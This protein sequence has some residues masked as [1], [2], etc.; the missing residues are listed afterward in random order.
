MEIPNRTDAE[1]QFARR[2]ARLTERQRKRLVDLLGSSPDPASVPESFWQEVANETEH[3]TLAILYLLFLASSYYHAGGDVAGAGIEST[4]KA[5]IDQ[6]AIIYSRDAASRLAQSYTET[7]RERFDALTRELRGMPPE[8]VTV[9]VVAE[10]SVKV[11]GPARAASVAVTETTAAQSAGG[12]AGTRLV[13]GLS[14][15]DKWIT[16]KDSKVCPVCRPLHRTKRDVW[17]LRFVDG[18]PAHPS[19]RCVIEY[20]KER[21]NRA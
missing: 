12:E 7:S 18:P 6:Q 2:M 5:S 15:A 13:F 11:L 19:C 16:E 21:R 14:T 8:K 3:E 17:G 10:A 9:K 4:T 1:T 20:V